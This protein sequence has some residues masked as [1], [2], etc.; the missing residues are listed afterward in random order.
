M[1]GTVPFPPLTSPMPTRSNKTH[2]AAVESA[3]SALTRNLEADS[4]TPL[5]PTEQTRQPAQ[6]ECGI[7]PNV[8]VTPP[9]PYQ[10]T[11]TAV[12]PKHH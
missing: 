8:Y 3:L 5:N 10:Q 6:P 7:V 11:V 12:K 4:Q 9:L 1:F 2:T